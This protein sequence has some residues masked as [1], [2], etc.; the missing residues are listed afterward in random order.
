MMHTYIIRYPITQW[1][2]DIIDIAFYLSTNYFYLS[3]DELAL[4]Q[5]FKNSIL[6]GTLAIF[7]NCNTVIQPYKT[8]IYTRY[9][10]V[11]TYFNSGRSPL[12]RRLDSLN[13]YNV[14]RILIGCFIY[15]Y[16]G[17]LQSLEQHNITV[18]IKYIN[19]F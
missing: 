15:L 8:W 10:C 5:I 12:V 2:N 4:I 17:T 11:Y 7:G 6:L 14:I 16:N 3:I 19:K 13:K 1:R 18:N 9:M